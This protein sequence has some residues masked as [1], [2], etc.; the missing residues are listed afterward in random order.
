MGNWACVHTTKIEN[1][2]H[3]LTLLRIDK[4]VLGFQAVLIEKR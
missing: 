4:T 3:L 2:A 1:R